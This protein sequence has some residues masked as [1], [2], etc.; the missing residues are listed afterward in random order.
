MPFW[1]LKSRAEGTIENVPALKGFQAFEI[2]LDQFLNRWLSGLEKDGL[3][4]G[5]NWSGKRATG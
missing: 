2:D 5:V 4:V 3:N 1:S